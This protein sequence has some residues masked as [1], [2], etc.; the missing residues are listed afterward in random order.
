[1]IENSTMMIYSRLKT[2][3]YKLGLT[4]YQ[5]E[6]AVYH[7]KQFG[8]Y[9]LPFANWKVHKLRLETEL[10]GVCSQALIQ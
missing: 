7:N 2:T 9:G 4:F 3:V 5:V 10:A 8:K 6:L 1:M